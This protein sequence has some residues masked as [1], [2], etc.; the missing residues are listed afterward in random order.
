MAFNLDRAGKYR[1]GFGNKIPL[2]GLTG[3]TTMVDT[4]ASN[5]RL[6]V[7]CSEKVE[8]TTCHAIKLQQLRK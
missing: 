1:V 7:T 3:R 2:V 6:R 4:V 8:A 5:I